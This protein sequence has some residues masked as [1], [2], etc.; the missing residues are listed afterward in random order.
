M[1]SHTIAG[2]SDLRVQK[3]EFYTCY[4]IFVFNLSET[5][6]IFFNQKILDGIPKPLI[7]SVDCV[8]LI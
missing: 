3:T 5:L 1:A 2:F 7:V 6:F 4:L 8:D